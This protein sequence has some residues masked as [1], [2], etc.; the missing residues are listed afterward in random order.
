MG[1]VFHS[2]RLD[3]EKCQGCTNCIKHCP[4]EAIRVRGGKAKII[5]SGTQQKGIHNFRPLH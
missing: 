5:N 3:D 2:V 1:N 4:T